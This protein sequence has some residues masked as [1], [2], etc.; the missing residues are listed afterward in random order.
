MFLTFTEWVDI[1]FILIWKDMLPYNTFVVRKVIKTRLWQGS[2]ALFQ[3][4]ESLFKCK[5]MLINRQAHQEQ[6]VCF[7][8]GYGIPR[9]FCYIL[10]LLSLSFSYVSQRKPTRFSVRHAHTLKFVLIDFSITRFVI[11]QSKID[12]PN[13]GAFLFF[14]VGV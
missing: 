8:T 2:T 5:G 14:Q 1:P 11:S 3:C 10:W 4:Q 13:S 9:K 6:L 7:S 12:I